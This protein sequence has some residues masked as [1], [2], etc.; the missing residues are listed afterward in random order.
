MGCCIL[1][2]LYYVIRNA[3]K[4]AVSTILDAI[5]VVMVVFYGGSRIHSLNIWLC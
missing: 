2:G 1:L 5:F 3:E 4:N